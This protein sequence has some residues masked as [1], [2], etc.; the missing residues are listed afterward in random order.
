MILYEYSRRMLLRW[1][2]RPAQCRRSKDVPPLPIH[3]AD[4]FM[5]PHVITLFN[6]HPSAG[7]SRANA[8]SRCRKFV[9]K[10]GEPRFRALQTSECN[11]LLDPARASYMILAQR[12]PGKNADGVAAAITAPPTALQRCTDTAG[13]HDHHKDIT[14]KVIPAL[15]EHIDS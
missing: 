14:S 5:I 6:H 7:G 10:H 3:T 4:L 15:T 13:S 9:V 12:Q 2:T 1:L 8:N 11:E